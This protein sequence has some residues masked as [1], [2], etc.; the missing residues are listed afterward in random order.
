MPRI[1]PAEGEDAL[2][3]AGR[4]PAL[5]GRLHVELGNYKTEEADGFGFRP[6]SVNGE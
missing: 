6:P 3:T 2:G 5:L 4:M 1:M